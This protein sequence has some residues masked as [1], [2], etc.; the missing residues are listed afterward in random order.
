MTELSI[1]RLRTH[2]RNIQR[3][4]RLLETRL[5]DLERQFIEERLSEEELAIEAIAAE[6]LPSIVKR[7]IASV[8]LVQ[9]LAAA[10]RNTPYLI[11]PS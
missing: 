3:Y 11:K 7:P 1:V 2:R 9:R 8:T 10:R 6:M 5:T 4:R